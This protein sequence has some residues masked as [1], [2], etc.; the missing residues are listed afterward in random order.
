MIEYTDPAEGFHGWLVRDTLTYGIC[1]GGMRVQPGLTRE[2]LARMARNMSRKMRISGLRVDGAKCGIDYDPAA[3]GKHAA[4]ARFMTAI[5]PY[6][7]SSY[8]MGPDLNVEMAELDAIGQ[9]LGLDSVKMAVAKAQGWDLP[10][11]TARYAILK[12]EIDGQPLGR[13]RV[14]FGV[15]VAAL[16]VLDYLGIPYAQATVAVQGFGALARAALFGL[17]QKGVRVVALADVE[18]CIIAEEGQGLDI[19]SLLRNEGT[20]LP[21][22]DPGSGVRLA[23]REEIF[24]IPCDILIPAAVEN[25]ISE[26]VAAR[27]R[28]RAVVPGANLAVT[29]GAELLLSGSGVLVLPDFLAGCGGSL[30]MDGL[31]GP[32]EPPAPAQVLA[33]V[34]QRMAE[35]VRRVLSRSETERISPTAAALRICAETVPQP[36][37]PYGNPIA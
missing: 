29:A 9:Q 3:A 33:H 36:G 31:F 20:L 14:G 25:S 23:S 8:S 17:V 12:Q 11:Y 37:R 24:D 1:A 7:R 27:L 35:M 19:K 15:G 6:I 26:Q 2:R 34:E 5:L 10:H 32:P 21:A 16:A 4:M 28:V 30:A 13:L 18:K 22:D